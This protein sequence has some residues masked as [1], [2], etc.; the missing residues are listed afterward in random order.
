MGDAGDVLR[1][2]VSENGRYL[3]DGKGEPFFW[4]G[5][6]GWGLLSGPTVEE[7]ELYLDNR[8]EKGFNV[9]QCVIAR[10]GPQPHDAITDPGYPDDFFESPDGELP[11]LDM[12]PATPNPKYFEHVDR[13]LELAEERQMILAMIPAWCIFMG[14]VLNMDNAYEYGLWLGQRY[15]DQDNI[16]WVLGGDLRPEGREDLV[17]LLAKGVTDGDGGRHLKTLHPNSVSSKYFHHDDWLDF[18]M[19]QSGHALDLPNYSQ[20]LRDYNLNPPKPVLDAEPRYEG[21]SSEVFGAMPEGRAEGIRIDD[22]Q[23]RIAA[24]NAVLSGALGH[25]YGANAVWEFWQPGTWSAWEPLEGWKTALDL[26]GGFHM[27]VMKDLMLSRE[28][29]LLEPDPKMVQRNLPERPR[30]YL[31]AARAKDGRF[32]YVY[33]PRRKRMEIDLSKLSGS[34]VRAAWFDPRTGETTLAGEYPAEGLQ[35]FTPP[36]GPEDPDYVLILEVAD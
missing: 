27:G 5:D 7:V 8:R 34:K 26:P 33:F 18:N 3:V 13:V 24:Y 20:V 15:R 2:G 28:W 29:W 23:V 32:A 6:T 31:P 14:G 19:I 21:L 30:D 11:W 12:N 17:R 1:L 36:T 10:W 35:R 25:T 9:V 22:H 16:I 4:L